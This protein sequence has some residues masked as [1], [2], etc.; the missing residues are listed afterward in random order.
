MDELLR[1]CPSTVRMSLKLSGYSGNFPRSTNANAK[2]MNS[3]TVNETNPCPES[4]PD[5]AVPDQG[6]K[7][8]LLG[9][10]LL[11]R[12]IK[13][14]RSKGGILLP[15]SALGEHSSGPKEYLVEGVGTGATDRKGNRI[16]IEISRGDRVIC[17]SYITG[18]VELPGVPELKIITTD[19]V[20]AIIPALDQ[21]MTPNEEHPIS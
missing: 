6:G 18:A 19:Q 12:W 2:P 5:D 8:R 14:D 15:E 7:A 11:V 4:I 13:P 20:L 21:V 1:A 17:Q 3:T 10:R 9:N 16:P